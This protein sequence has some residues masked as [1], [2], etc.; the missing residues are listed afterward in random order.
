MSQCDHELAIATEQLN[1]LAKEV[2]T[3]T[4]KNEKYTQF[5]L[6]YFL[7]KQCQLIIYTKYI[8]IYIYVFDTRYAKLDTENALLKGD[9]SRMVRLIA[10]QQQVVYNM[11]KVYK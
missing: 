7:Y 9:I 1:R 3:V 4:E 6:L 2:A 5:F 8:Y 11:N 10:Q